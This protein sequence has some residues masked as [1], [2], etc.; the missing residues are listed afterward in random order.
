M[1]RS[2]SPFC[3]PGWLRC[4]GCCAGMLPVFP[5]LWAQVVHPGVP[6]V[7]SL[8]VSCL[9]FKFCL[10][11]LATGN[12]PTSAWSLLFDICRGHLAVRERQTGQGNGEEIP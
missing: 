1:A 8:V 7:G 10:H 12:P 4:A 2:K 3:A 9:L 6:S 11:T 5:T